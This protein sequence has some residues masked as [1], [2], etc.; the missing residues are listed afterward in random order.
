MADNISQ[1]EFDLIK[2]TS[3]HERGFHTQL[4]NSVPKYTFYNDNPDKRQVETAFCGKM[5]FSIPKWST[6]HL[7]CKNITRFVGSRS[8]LLEIFVTLH[9]QIDKHRMVTGIIKHNNTI[10]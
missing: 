3:R 10:F 2:G 7:L 4:M 5:S 8:V 6:W 1:M 9:I